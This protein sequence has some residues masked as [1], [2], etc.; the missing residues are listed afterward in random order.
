[1]KKLTEFG[2]LFRNLR[3]ENGF[4]E[5]DFAEKVGKSQS[6][7]S[8]IETKKI[9]LLQFDFVTA[10][11][12]AFGLNKKQRHEFL[13]KAMACSKK[14]TIPL[15]GVTIISQERFLHL[16]AFIIDNYEPPE[17]NS[18]IMWAKNCLWALKNDNL[19]NTL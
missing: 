14:M 4:N 2:K 10:C 1:M 11:M 5:K 17:S 15:D 9:P 8:A 18:E 16:L 19:Y 7:I 13:V 6:Y 3:I 12:D